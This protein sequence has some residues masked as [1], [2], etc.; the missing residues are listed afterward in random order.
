M[1]PVLSLNMEAPPTPEEEGVGRA[2]EVSPLK[3]LAL[4]DKAKA[5]PLLKAQQPESVADVGF[6]TYDGKPLVSDFNDY[7]IQI[8]QAFRFNAE[9]T[10]V[11]RVAITNKIDA[12]LIYQPDSFALRAGNRLYPQS[13]SD[14]D[15]TVPPKGRSIVYFAV[16]G[17]PDGGRNNLSLKNQFTVLVTRLSPP[18]PVVTVT[19]APRASHSSTQR[20]AMKPRDFLNFFKTKSGRLVAFAALF[21]GGLIIFSVIRKHHTAPEDAIAVTPLAT[22]NV[23][24]KPQVVQSV[25]RPMQA[26]H[27]PPP[28]SEPTTRQRRQPASTCISPPQS[29]AGGSRARRN[30]SR[31]SVCLPTAR[32][33]FAQPKKL[34]A[35]YAPFG[36]LIPCETVITVDSASIQ[37]PIVGLVTEN[38]YFGGKLVIPAG[39]EVHGMAQTDHQRERIASSTSWTLVWQNG[40]EMRIKAIALDR[41]FDNSTNQ[42]GWAITDGS[43]G[44]RG[45][46]IKSDNLAD[47]KLF[48]A[49]FLSGAASA[50]TEK[51]QTIFGPINSPTLNNAPF[52][53]AQAV[54]QTY[55]QQILDSIQKNGFYVRVPSGKQF[56]LYV[57]Q[58]IDRA[59]AT[60][61]GAAS[62]EEKDEQPATTPKR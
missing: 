16:T 53:G 49:T 19:N 13:I 20:P 60:F 17:T 21:A 45:E 38:V 54:L 55:A 37:T 1:L 33:E 32:R 34:S 57:L 42:S 46:I 31:P 50:L 52:A 12:P 44:L 43:A 27:P 41:E 11:F 56:Y 24:G 2:P 10:L 47:I 30:R 23:G 8:E 48:A 40:E 3:L 36:R 7:E 22:N 15:G 35:V 29:F 4:L 6:T 28:K 58:T 61:G 39:T 18:P 62:V 14:A 51:Q 26:F 59:D 25:V 5:F 9:D